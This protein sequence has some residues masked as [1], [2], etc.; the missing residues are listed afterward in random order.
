MKNEH[1][2]GC[3]RLLYEENEGLCPHC[4]AE[5]LE[6]RDQTRSEMG[7]FDEDEESPH[8]LEN[9]LLDEDERKANEEDIDDEDEREPL[10]DLP[11]DWEPNY[12]GADARERQLSDYNQKF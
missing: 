9:A 3:G 7:E 8:A 11:Y 4:D 5:L 10:D 6:Q 2:Q 12:D 1:C